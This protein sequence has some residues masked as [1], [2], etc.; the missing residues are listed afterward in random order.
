MLGMVPCPKKSK[1]EFSSSSKLIKLMYIPPFWED[2]GVKKWSPFWDTGA[3]SPICWHLNMGT[4]GNFGQNPPDTPRHPPDISASSSVHHHDTGE[5]DFRL[6]CES[7]AVFFESAKSGRYNLLYQIMKI[8]SA[9]GWFGKQRS[10]NIKQT[11]PENVTMCRGFHAFH[12][13]T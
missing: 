1:L 3:W 8:S 2:V 12:A 10:T 6:T 11:L 5:T 7:W 9:R 4:F 13:P